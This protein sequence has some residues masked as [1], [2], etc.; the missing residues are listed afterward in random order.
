MRT[1]ELRDLSPGELL[2]LTRR[3]AVPD[4]ELRVRAA[5]IVASV[6]DGGDAALEAAADRYGGGLASG[7]LRVPTREIGD[8]LAT[9]HGRTAAALGKARDAISACHHPQLPRDDETEPAPGVRVARRWSPMRRVAVYVPGGRNAYPSSLLMGAVPAQIAGVTEVVVA[10]PAD[11]TGA[12]GSSVLAAA[13]MLGL[14]EVYAMGGAQ[15][16]AA[17]AYGTE[18]ISRVDKIVGP[19]NAWVTAAKLAVLGDV[20]V[21]LPAGPSEALVLSD[22]TASARLIAA[23]LICQS[24]HGPDSPVVLVTTDGAGV[25][26]ILEAVADLLP[27]LSRAAIISKALADHGLIVTAPSIGAALDFAQSY[28]PEHLTIHTADAEEHA[29]TVTAAGSVFVGPWAPESAGD[30][31]TGAN[32]ILPTGGLAAGYGPLGVED[33]GSWRQVQYLTRRGLEGIR[34]T[35]NALADAEGLGAHKLAVEVRF[36]SGAPE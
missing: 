15:A 7:R 24:E 4:P 26:A 2:R 18:T 32:H 22:G 34:E 31:A 20:A 29:E 16:I 5:E 12:V 25:P 3:S 9:L 6:R 10:T 27:G 33:F 19:G 36:E 35:V 1:V 13:G 23:D 11:E 30:Y 8:A 21:D 14:D 17:L 28:A